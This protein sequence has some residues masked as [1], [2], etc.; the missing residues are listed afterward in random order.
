[1]LMRGSCPLA[2]PL[3]LMLRYKSTG[4]CAATDRANMGRKRVRDRY[5]CYSSG[6]FFAI[7]E[8]LQALQLVIATK[9]TLDF[10][11]RPSM[12]R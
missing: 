7:V 8:V 11:E 1:M 6:N 10:H 12:P 4:T 3:S 5:L 2:P 9:K